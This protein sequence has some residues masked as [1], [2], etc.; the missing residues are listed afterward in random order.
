MKLNTL[1][2][3]FSKILQN[4]TMNWPWRTGNPQSQNQH[5]LERQYAQHSGPAKH[6]HKVDARPELSVE[7]I[8]VSADKK[9]MYCKGCVRSKG[10]KSE[11]NVVVAVEWLDEDQKA[12]NTDWKRIEMP[13]NG[14][15]V[16]LLPNSLRSFIVKAPLDRR[17]KWVNAYAFSSGH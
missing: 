3:S 15:A 10:A 9:Y 5:K 14:N 7:D 4:Q 12:L 11:L 6:P 2:R 8:N 1:N 13:L 17:A 16:S